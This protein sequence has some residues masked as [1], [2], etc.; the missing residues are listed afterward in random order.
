ML[1]NMLHKGVNMLR[2]PTQ[3]KHPWGQHAPEYG[4]V[5]NRKGGQYAPESEAKPN[6]GGSTSAGLAV[7]ISQPGH[8]STLKILRF[9]GVNILRII[10]SVQNFGIIIDFMIICLHTS[11]E[12]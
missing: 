6:F 11:G 2:N 8:F 7:E 5:Q 9:S 12:V 4:A 1:R 10:Q 3:T